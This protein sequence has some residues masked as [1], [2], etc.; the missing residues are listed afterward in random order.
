[1]FFL[2]HS[3]LIFSAL[4]AVHWTLTIIQLEDLV[5]GIINACLQKC[6][7]TYNLVHPIPYTIQEFYRQIFIKQKMK[8]RFLHLP[9]NITVIALEVAEFLKIPLPLTSQNLLGL[10]HL[11]IFESDCEKLGIVLLNKTR[12]LKLK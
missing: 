11:Q 3:R 10:K 4:D 7:G 5:K 8:P 2:K 9:G 12:S 1:M 6:T